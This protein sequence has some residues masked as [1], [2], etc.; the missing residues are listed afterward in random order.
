[1][2]SPRWTVTT[3]DQLDSRLKDYL[4]AKKKGLHGQSAVLRQF[5]DE[6]LAAEGF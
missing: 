3:D 6:R 4:H 5:I 1:M 2:P